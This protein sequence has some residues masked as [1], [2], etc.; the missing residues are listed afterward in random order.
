MPKNLIATFGGIEYTWLKYAPEEGI[1]GNMITWTIDKDEW[2]KR[3]GVV[4]CEECMGGG[5]G[6][7]WD[8]E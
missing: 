1:C 5:R 8:R 6:C 3:Q 2:V 4:V 7:A